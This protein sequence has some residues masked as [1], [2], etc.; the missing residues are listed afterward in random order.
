MIDIGDL[1][2]MEMEEGWEMR[3]DS[4]SAMYIILVIDT[5]KPRRHHSTI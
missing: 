5:L 1:E 3:N 4:K 2:G